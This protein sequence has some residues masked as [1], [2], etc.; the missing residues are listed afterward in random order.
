MTTKIASKNRPKVHHVKAVIFD[1]D[2]TLVHS[3]V[4]FKLLRKETITFLVSKGLTAEQFSTDMKTLEIMQLATDLFQKNGLPEHDIL[5]INREVEELW[6][7]VELRTVDKTTPI[8]GA[9][10]TLVKLKERD[11]KIGIVTRGC[12]EYAIEALKRTQLLELVDVIVGR[13]DTYQP[14]PSPDPLN[15]AIQMLN[16]TNDEVVMVGD[17][18][19]D[20]QCAWSAKVRFMGVHLEPTKDSLR[21]SRCRIVLTDLVKLFERLN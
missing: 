12:R 16:L 9:R 7:R 13:G 21:D 10:E 6:N 15:K 14:K 2:G 3:A 8:E 17:N 19:N 5:L 4:D 18:I 20:A 1:L 11:I